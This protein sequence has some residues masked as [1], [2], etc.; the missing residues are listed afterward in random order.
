[1]NNLTPLNS[2]LITPH[3]VLDRYFRGR[4][5]AFTVTDAKQLTIDAWANTVGREMRNWPTHQPYLALHD[6]SSPQIV[7]TPYARARA[8]E[9]YAIRPELQ[10][11]IA[12]VLPQTFAAQLIQLFVKNQRQGNLVTEMFLD[13]QE[14]LAWLTRLIPSQDR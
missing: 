11:R 4:L 8:Q 2:E 7:V 3:V 5:V 10:G 6:L 1:M 14:A 13:R 12:V 9:L